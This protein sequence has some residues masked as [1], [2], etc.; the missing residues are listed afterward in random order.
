[1]KEQVFNRVSGPCKNSA[2]CLRRWLSES[3]QPPS[4]DSIHVM[5]GKYIQF[6]PPR[7][8]L[9]ASGI[10]RATATTAQAQAGHPFATLSSSLKNPAGR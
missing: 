3:R 6:I 1:M 10:G 5:R 8:S 9:I 7:V 2:W 4:D